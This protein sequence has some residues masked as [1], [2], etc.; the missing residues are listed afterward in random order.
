MPRGL[1]IFILVPRQTPAYK[2]IINPVPGIRN[3]DGR[4]K[5]GTYFL[6]CQRQFPSGFGMSADK[7][8]V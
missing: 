1:E 5:Q 6:I 8:P 4:E 7:F 2:I 3:I